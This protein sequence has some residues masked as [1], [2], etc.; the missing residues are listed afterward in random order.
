MTLT[1]LN[2]ETLTALAG[3][4]PLLCFADHISPVALSQGC[5]RLPADLLDGMDI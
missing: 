1:P 2:P 5:V 3:T 4:E